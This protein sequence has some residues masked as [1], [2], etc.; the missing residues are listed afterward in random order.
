[1]NE[2]EIIKY[3]LEANATLQRLK[4]MMKFIDVSFP[5]VLFKVM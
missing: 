4:F 1:M 2:A 5:R 3:I